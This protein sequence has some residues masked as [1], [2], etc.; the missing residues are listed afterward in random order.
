MICKVC[1]NKCQYCHKEY[2]CLA[3]MDWQ[4]ENRIGIPY[5]VKKEKTNLQKIMDKYSY[6]ED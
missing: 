4:V 6:L 3:C 1:K 5:N 2:Q